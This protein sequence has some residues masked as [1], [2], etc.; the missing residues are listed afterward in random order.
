MDFITL[1]LSLLTV[2]AAISGQSD[3]TKGNTNDVEFGTIIPNMDA[4]PIEPTEIIGG[5]P[6]SQSHHQGQGHHAGQSRHQSHGRHVRHEGHHK[7]ASQIESS[8]EHRRIEHN[9]NGHRDGITTQHQKRTPVEGMFYPLADT[10]V[11]FET[12]ESSGYASYTVDNSDEFWSNFGNGDNADS[13]QGV[14][15]YKEN[16]IG[17]E[18]LPQVQVTKTPPKDTQD[19]LTTQ[20]NHHKLTTTV[21]E[22]TTS[23]P[24]ATP[25]EATGTEA[26]PNLA[27]LMR[28]SLEALVFNLHDQVKES[29]IS[30]STTR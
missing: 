26:T 27:N 28:T 9:Q 18:F 8:N 23:G 20:S 30:Q 13:S 21:D 3:S 2:T 4:K 15:S 16:S 10:N 25:T 29:R 12:I 22:L 19:R 17:K 11:D 24:N 14:V 7:H 6:I 1:V 5:Q